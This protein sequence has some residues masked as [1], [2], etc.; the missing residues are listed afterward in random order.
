LDLNNKQKSLLIQILSK[1]WEKLTLKVFY[2]SMNDLKEGNKIFT[3]EW[4]IDNQKVIDIEELIDLCG[5]EISK[6]AYF[7]PIAK[8]VFTKK[9]KEYN[10]I[11]NAN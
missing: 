7:E 5:D 4:E 9:N 6:K 11:M 2:V 8:A 1:E 10:E 3:K